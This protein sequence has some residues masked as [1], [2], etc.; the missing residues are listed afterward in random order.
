MPRFQF[1]LQKILNL[2]ES[3]EEQAE[4][5]LAAAQRAKAV[6]AQKLEAARA[7]AQSAEAE[8]RRTVSHQFNAGEALVHQRYGERKNIAAAE[9]AQS[10][11]NSER[12]VREKRG[13]LI[14]ISR[15]RQILSTLREKHQKEHS[16]ESMRIEQ[17]QMDDDAARRSA[18]SANKNIDAGRN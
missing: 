3:L 16:A 14:E 11:A 13:Q 8:R 18:A 7:E 10:V 2:R 1:R 17:K 12:I 5:R 15:Q 6:E 9:A 4:L